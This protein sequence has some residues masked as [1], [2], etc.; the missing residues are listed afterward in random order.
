MVRVD[1][2][3]QRIGPLRQKNSRN[4]MSSASSEL[5]NDHGQNNLLDNGEF[6]IKIII[7][8]RNRFMAPPPGTPE[9]GDHINCENCLFCSKEAHIRE[10][11]QYDWL[12]ESHLEKIDINMNNQAD[13]KLYQK[14]KS[15]KSKQ[16]T[17]HDIFSSSINY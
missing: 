6:P 15:R 7:T 13:L 8:D 10:K 17:G 16:K 4:N 12:S 3:I 11:M 5:S 14:I 1:W 2:I 9:I